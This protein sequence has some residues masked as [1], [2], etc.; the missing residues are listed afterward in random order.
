M[1]RGGRM[2]AVNA[3]GA[4][5]AVGPYSQAVRCGGLVFTS[6]QIPLDP[7][8]GSLVEGDFEDRIR[9][10]LANLDAVLGAAGS[11]RSRVVKVTVFLTDMALFGSLNAV[12]AEFFGEHRPA[13]SVV[14][15]AALPLGA[16]V[17]FEAVAEIP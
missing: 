10:A 8:T 16:P 12:Y 11:D 9:R 13:R 6:G 17:E 4:P 14:E 2:D 1:A 15:V 7:E 5:A 3:E